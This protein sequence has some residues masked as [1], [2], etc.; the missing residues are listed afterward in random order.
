MAGTLA[1]T[2]GVGLSEALGSGTLRWSV[3]FTSDSHIFGGQTVLKAEATPPTAV[4]HLFTSA[5]WA[6]SSHLSLP[7]ASSVGGIGPILSA[8]SVLA[9][10]CDSRLSD[11]VG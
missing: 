8:D 6:Q 9:V 11:G 2:P 3:A 4:R 10:S 5:G 1:E 7:L